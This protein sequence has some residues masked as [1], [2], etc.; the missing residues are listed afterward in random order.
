MSLEL[1][2]DTKGL[3]NSKERGLW[4]N[5]RSIEHIAQIEKPGP[6]PLVRVMVGANSRGESFWLASGAE[7]MIKILELFGGYSPHQ[8]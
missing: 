7:C 1:N 4:D 5:V 6:Y 2:Q 8:D 3:L